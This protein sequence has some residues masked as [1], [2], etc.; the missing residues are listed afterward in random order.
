MTDRKLLETSLQPIPSKQLAKP[1]TRKVSYETSPKFQTEQVQFHEESLER[2]PT[3]RPGT[4]YHKRKRPHNVKQKSH[5]NPFEI[6]DITELPI[7]VNMVIEPDEQ[8]ILN[9][10]HLYT[11][12]S[13][14]TSTP[15]MVDTRPKRHNIFDENLCS[16]TPIQHSHNETNPKHTLF[17]RLICGKP[18]VQDHPGMFVETPCAFFQTN[19][20]AK[21]M[22]RQGLIFQTH[23]LA[24]KDNYVSPLLQSD[25]LCTPNC[26]SSTGNMNN[27]PANKYKCSNK[28]FSLRNKIDM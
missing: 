6:T 8:H 24:S 5:E 16:A 21:T 3:L 10:T 7:S 4:P 13:T 2:D 22:A 26:V 15:T 27:G 9:N 14:S 11:T 23:P 28:I 17:S 1:V 20:A 18:V 19:M 25:R 12:R